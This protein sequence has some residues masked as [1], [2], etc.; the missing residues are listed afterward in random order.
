MI[1]DWP[2]CLS[3]L[4][5][6]WP[7]SLCAPF[8]YGSLEDTTLCQSFASFIRPLF[9]QSGGNKQWDSQV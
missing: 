6:C 2:T 9:I 7:Y 3:S 5:G 4:A 1:S 8:D